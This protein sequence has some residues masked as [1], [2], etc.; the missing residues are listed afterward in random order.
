MFRLFI[1]IPISAINTEHAAEQARELISMIITE[2]MKTNLKAA[3]VEQ[4]NYRL[5]HD[6]DRQKSNYLIMNENGHCSNKK[7]RMNL[8]VDNEQN[9]V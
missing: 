5:G 4:V 7:C 3:N 2:D 8:V 9:L 1:D 6:E